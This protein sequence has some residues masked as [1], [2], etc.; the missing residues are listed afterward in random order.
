MLGACSA[1]GNHVAY[2]SVACQHEHWYAAVD[3]HA[4][5]CIGAK[6]GM[7]PRGKKG[8]KVRK[9]NVKNAP[10]SLRKGG[11]SEGLSLGGKSGL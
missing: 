9:A 11:K 7:P 4:Q 3:G 1:C 5:E 10:K 2:C 8:R 6:P